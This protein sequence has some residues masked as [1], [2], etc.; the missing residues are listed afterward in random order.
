MPIRI[1]SWS[2]WLTHEMRLAAAKEAE[3]C[4]AEDDG[5][6]A[7]AGRTA[8]ERKAREAGEASRLRALRAMVAE[9]EDEE[10]RRT[11]TG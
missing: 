1:G 7:E 5:T 10:A 9:E 2:R 6:R 11:R 8:R 4:K 3:E